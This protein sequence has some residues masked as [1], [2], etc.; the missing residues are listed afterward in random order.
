MQWKEQGDREGTWCAWTTPFHCFLM[1]SQTS[2]GLIREVG[3]VDDLFPPSATQRRPRRPQRTFCSKAGLTGK[4]SLSCSVTPVGLES[5]CLQR[6][7]GLRLGR[8][9][10]PRE[11]GGQ[12]GASVGKRVPGI[13]PNRTEGWFPCRGNTNNSNKNYR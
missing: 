3:S 6:P 12:A 13:S 8:G 2:E 7:S 1:E 10:G 9:A 4:Q 5:S 11:Q